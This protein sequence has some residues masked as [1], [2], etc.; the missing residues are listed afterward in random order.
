MFYVTPA[1]WKMEHYLFGT[2]KNI[3]WN[4]IAAINF[5]FGYFR[6]NSTLGSENHNLLAQYR[7]ASVTFRLEFTVQQHVV[8][9]KEFAA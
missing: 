2:R 1:T 6:E 3:R 8:L 4:F 5:N 7:K 9:E